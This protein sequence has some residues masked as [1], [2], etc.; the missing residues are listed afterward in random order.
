[1]NKIEDFIKAVS[2]IVNDRRYYYSQN[3]ETEFATDCSD[4]LLRGLKNI[5]L[6]VN[7]A[8]YTGN[9]IRCLTGKGLFVCIPF[10]IGKARRGDIFLRHVSDTDAHTV[11]YLGDRKIV[12][13]CNKKN[14]LRFTQYYFNRYQYILR[15]KDGYSVNT[16]TT[17]RRGD[18]CVEVGLLQMFLN[19]YESNRL[20]IDC[21]FGPKTEEALK[22]FQA[23]YSLIVD[24]IAGVETWTKIYFIM[25][26]SS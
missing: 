18:I 3:R 14:G 22:N 21:D 5:G 12:E 26:Q 17:I 6:N 8:T 16:M 1:M 2:D 25:A 4:L 20:I 10:D 9:M 11:L 15:F 24:G 23:K 13:A 7:G 19:K